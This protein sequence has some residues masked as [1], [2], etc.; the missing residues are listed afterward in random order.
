[1]YLSSKSGGCCR[2]RLAG[3]GP[4][5]ELGPPPPPLPPPAAAPGGGMSG[6]L[7]PVGGCLYVEVEATPPE[8]E[9]ERV[10]RG[11]AAEIAQGVSAAG[12]RGEGVVMYQSARPARG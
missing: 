2:A 8:R 7:G 4:S 5:G 1:M 12:E 10:V 6:E 11:S 9:G 3:G